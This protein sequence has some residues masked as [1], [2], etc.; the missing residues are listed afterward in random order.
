MVQ[1]KDTPLYEPPVLT[2]RAIADKMATMD[3]EVKVDKELNS[4]MIIFVSDN[5]PLLNDNLGESFG[6][7]G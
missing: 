2:L 3:K 6:K 1:Q 5:E 4:L 7:Q